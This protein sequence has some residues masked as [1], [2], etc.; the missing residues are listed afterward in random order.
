MAELT[1]L[2]GGQLFDVGKVIDTLLCQIFQGADA[3]SG[4]GHRPFHGRGRRD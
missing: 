1:C 3:A 4:Q 2:L